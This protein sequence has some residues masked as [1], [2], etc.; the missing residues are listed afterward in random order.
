MWI[1]GFKYT[2]SREVH[3]IDFTERIR[4]IH[5][6]VIVTRSTEDWRVM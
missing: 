1:F 4:V 2:N 5:E 3:N 6:A